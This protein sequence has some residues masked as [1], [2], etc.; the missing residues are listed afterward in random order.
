MIYPNS[1]QN[2]PLMGFDLESDCTKHPASI[3]HL[4]DYSPYLICQGDGTICQLFTGKDF[5]WNHIM[6]GFL[7]EHDAPYSNH[8]K[9]IRTRINPSI[10]FLLKVFF[11]KPP[12]FS[13]E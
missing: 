3:H 12:K 13:S 1:H 2:D 5:S 9:T 7:S 8:L 11:P 10:N 4:S 6:D